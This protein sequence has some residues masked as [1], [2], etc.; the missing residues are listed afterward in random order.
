[1]SL[2]L[3]G[4]AALAWLYPDE[5]TNAISAV[6]DRVIRSGAIVPTLWRIE[7]ANSL[8]VGVRRRRITAKER[9]E[10]LSDLDQ[11]K[12]ATDA[13]TETHIWGDTLRL[14]DR[15]SLTVYDAT[16]LELALRASL[17][18]ATLDRDLRLAAQKEQVPLLGI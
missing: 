2:V 12:I 11:L 6:F 5:T 7:I 10:S 13:E 4:S 1:M 3:D 9:T 17:P 18:L 8:T 14:A 15:H 16:Y